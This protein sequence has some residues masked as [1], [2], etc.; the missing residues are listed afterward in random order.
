MQKTKNILL[1]SVLL[2]LLICSVIYSDSLKSSV[3][4]SIMLCLEIIVPSLYFFMVI[5]SMLANSAFADFFAKVSTKF[6]KAVFGF[7]GKIFAI[8]L[9]SQIGGY[10]IGT[11]LLSQLYKNGEITQRQAMC[12]ACFCFSSGPAFILGVVADKAAFGAIMLSC[13]L[14]NLAAAF[15]FGKISLGT[16]A[17][18]S[19]CKS[20][21]S[22]VKSVKDSADALLNICIMILFM[23]SVLTIAKNLGLTMLAAKVFHVCTDTVSAIFE[24]TNV[25]AVSSVPICAFLLSFGGI[26]VALQLRSIAAF[27]FNMAKFLAARAICAAF[28]ALICKLIYKPCAQPLSAAIAPAGI[29][30]SDSNIVQASALLLMCCILL[31]KNSRQTKNNVL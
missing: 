5:S 4:A 19:K 3:A 25:L 7:D 11:K 9:L 14:S 12:C 16:F 17:L 8:F 30:K 18:P 23:R 29:I 6:T 26:C 10:P 22:L 21:V 1:I 13:L 15:F 31:A 27:R 28:C 24:V 2:L 20:D